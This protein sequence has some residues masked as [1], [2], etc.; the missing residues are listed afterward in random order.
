MRENS[1]WEEIERQRVAR[2]KQSKEEAEIMQDVLPGQL[3]VGVP[4]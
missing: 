2:E 1:R 4:D 3:C